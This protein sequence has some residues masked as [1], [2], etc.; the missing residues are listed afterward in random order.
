[1]PH[2]VATL[3]YLSQIYS[4]YIRGDM[5]PLKNLN[6]HPL[7]V[8]T[9]YREPQSVQCYPLLLILIYLYFHP[10]KIVLR[11]RDPQFQVVEN[12]S[13]L[14]NLRSTF[15]KFWCFNTHF[16]P[17]ISDFMANKTNWK[18]QWSWSTGFRTKQNISHS[19]KCMLIL[20]IIFFLRDKQK[21][22]PKI[23]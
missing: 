16:A 22:F 11:Y 8:M 15:C 4:Y 9:R 17:N 2:L 6:F 12:Y 18:G 5:S 1:M 23:A 14:F 21:D 10:L 20:L 7:E 3:I 19:Y 13:Y